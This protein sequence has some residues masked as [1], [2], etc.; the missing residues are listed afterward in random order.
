MVQ[1][2]TYKE[3]AQRVKSLEALIMHSQLAT[4]QLSKENLITDINPAFS[5]IFGFKRE[6][7]VGKNIDYII[8]PTEYREEAKSLTRHTMNGEVIHEITKRRKKDGT[9]IDVEIFAGPLDAYGQNFGAYAQYL[10]ITEHEKTKRDLDERE[11]RYRDLYENAPNAYFSVGPNAI[12]RRCNQR[13]RDL[14]GYSEEELVGRPV[15][16]LYADRPN[17]KE[18]AKQIFVIFRK[19]QQIIDEEMQMQKADGTPVW[20][21]LTVNAIRD[22]Q[23]EIMESRSMVVDITERKRAG[24]ALRESEEKYRTILESIEDGY[25][26]V[27]TDGNFIF[28]N[29]A[30]C[31]MGGYSKDEIMSMS[32]RQF[33]DQKNF[34]EVY[35]AFNIVYKTG[36]PTKGFDYAII[37]KDGS[38]RYV[39]VSISLRKNSKGHPIGFQGIMRDVT[40][41]KMGEEALRKASALET[42]TTV[43]ENFI[44]DSLGNLLT[45]IYAHIELCKIQDSID[46]IT[47]GI[48]RLL[49]GINA[50]RWS[51]KLRESSLGIISSV[52]IRSI[53]GLLISGQRLKTY[54]EEEI[55]VD[56]NVKLRFVFDP[57]KEGALTLEELPL[58]SGSEIEIATAL[59]ETLINAIESYD[60]QK[61]GEVMVSAKK[62]DHNLI[63]EI[64]DQGRGM[65]SDEREKFQLPF[66]KILG[67]KKSGRLGLGAYIAC[68]SAKYCGGDIQIESTKGV[69]TT[70]S[71]ILRVKP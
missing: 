45:P 43:L 68:E 1:R 7:V 14:L 55:S 47:K 11:K 39:E 69:G 16:D 63:L 41:R 48:T 42:L 22:A 44:G 71:I 30:F 8:V 21:S 56:P 23:G 18:K 2:L 27:D 50:Y 58:V 70:A 52:D 62:A 54:E 25:Y 66:F 5:Q 13:A 32:Y 33:M 67:M 4:V 24:D 38:K 26:E 60:P 10:D 51:S 40:D 3:M 17:G 15:M 20:V 28:F 49:K 12:I 37:M 53:L 65:T 9:L 34:E 57:K 31:K 46:E 19:G 59:Q 29:D 36:K 61:G 6:E 35:K 64:A